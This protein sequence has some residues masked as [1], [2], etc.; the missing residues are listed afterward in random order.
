MEELPPPNPIHQASYMLAV[1][2]YFHCDKFG[3]EQVH[4]DFNLKTLN[5]SE[6]Y[7]CATAKV[8]VIS[9]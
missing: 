4:L 1:C 3:V 6:V 7:V 8:T 2:C 9:H 5:E